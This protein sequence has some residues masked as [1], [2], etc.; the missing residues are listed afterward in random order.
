MLQVEGDTLL[1]GIQ[2][3]QGHRAAFNTDAA[4]QGFADGR[5]DFDHPGPGHGQHKGGIGAVIDLTE[6]KDGDPFQGVGR[7]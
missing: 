6:V 3:G 7:R 2:H 4:T 1:I 5:F